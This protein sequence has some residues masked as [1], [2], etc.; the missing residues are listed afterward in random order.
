[1]EEEKKK[2]LTPAEVIEK[3]AQ[4]YQPHPNKQLGS[5]SARPHGSYH[6]PVKPVFRPIVPY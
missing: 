3:C 1:M 4:E 5:E 6:P 2:R